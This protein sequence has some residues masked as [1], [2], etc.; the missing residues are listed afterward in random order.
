VVRRHAGK[1]LSVL[2]P[3]AELGVA[4]QAIR[5]NRHGCPNPCVADGNRKYRVKT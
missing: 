3:T 4:A 1:E 2:L 5:L